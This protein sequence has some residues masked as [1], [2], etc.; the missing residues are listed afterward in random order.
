M[1]IL[2]IFKTISIDSEYVR[3]TNKRNKEISKHREEIKK[4]LTNITY[5]NILGVVYFGCRNPTDISKEIGYDKPNNLYKHLSYLSGNS[6]NYKY[7]IHFL[8]KK[9]FSHKNVKYYIDYKG[10][11][12]FIAEEMLEVPFIFKRGV[13]NKLTKK[14][15]KHFSKIGNYYS[16]YELFSSFIVLNSNIEFDLET[17]QYLFLV[18]T[19]KDYRKEFKEMKHHNISSERLFYFACKFYIEE[20]LIKS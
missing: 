17:L 3:K 10:V 12:R 2:N 13:S 9:E 4:F 6:A 14:L 15:E 20:K 18:D 16:L 5:Y 11:L 7:L 8:K 1:S 19:L